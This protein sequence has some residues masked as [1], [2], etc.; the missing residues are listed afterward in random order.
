MNSKLYSLRPRKSISLLIQKRKSSHRAKL[1][2]DTN[3]IN[4]RRVLR[5][6]SKFC[7]TS[8]TLRSKDKLNIVKVKTTGKVVR[9]G[10]RSKS[11]VKD[12]KRVASVSSRKKYIKIASQLPNKNISYGIKFKTMFAKISAGQ[13]SKQVRKK[14]IAKKAQSR[15]VVVRGSPANPAVPSTSKQSLIKKVVKS[16]KEIKPVAKKTQSKKSV[17]KRKIKKVVHVRSRKRNFKRPVKKIV[18]RTNTANTNA[19]KGKNKRPQTLQPL[20]CSKKSQTSPTSSNED[21]GKKPQYCAVCLN[22]YRFPIK[23]PC[24][25]TFCFLCA[26]GFILRNGRCA[27]CRQ[28]VQRSFLYKPVMVNKVVLEETNDFKWFYEGSCNSWWQYDDESNDIIEEAFQNGSEKCDVMIAGFM[29]E[30]N[31]KEKFQRRK[32]EFSISRRIKR[33]KDTINKKGIAGVPIQPSRKKKCLML[34]RLQ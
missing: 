13:N 25:H 5:S 18:K 29:Y 15:Q 34:S 30:V 21:A 19:K 7:S 28:I 6:Y 14:I 3:V 11:Q 23:L 20:A 4:G 26:K 24:S 2:R 32:Y 31:L 16:K 33:A 9:E 8:L 1:K 10:Q 17:V 12:I 27:L 22:E